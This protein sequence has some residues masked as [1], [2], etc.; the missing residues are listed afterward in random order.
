MKLIIIY[1]V[2][3]SDAMQTSSNPSTNTY[4]YDAKD[5]NDRTYSYFSA[6][7]YHKGDTIWY[8]NKNLKCKNYGT[9]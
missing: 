7:I 8:D 5:N 6:K 1:F 9:E 2:L 4:K 3:L